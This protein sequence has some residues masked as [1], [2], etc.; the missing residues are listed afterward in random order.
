[1]DDEAAIDKII[2]Y[3]TLPG[4]SRHHWGTDIDIIDAGPPEVVMFCFPKNFTI[5]DP[6]IR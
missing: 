4:T 1:M 3:S 5:M 2:E 6:T